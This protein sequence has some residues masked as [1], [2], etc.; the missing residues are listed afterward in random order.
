LPSLSC[1]FEH[2]LL[3][4]PLHVHRVTD[5]HVH[6][7]WNRHEQGS[8]KLNTDGSISWAWGMVRLTVVID[9][10]KLQESIGVGDD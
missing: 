9:A 7:H 10:V 6:L 3:S 2:L 5:L 1:I 4:P 8:V